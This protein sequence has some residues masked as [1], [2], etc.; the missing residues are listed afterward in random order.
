MWPTRDPF[1]KINLCTFYILRYDFDFFLIMI[2]QTRKIEEFL[3]ILINTWIIGPGIVHRFIF[4][5]GSLVGLEK[6]GRHVQ[7]VDLCRE[8]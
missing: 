2:T 1:S 5:N 6:I 3:Q 7:D 4:E 8:L